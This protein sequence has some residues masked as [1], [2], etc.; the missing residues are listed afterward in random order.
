[1]KIFRLHIATL[2]LMASTAVHAQ[3]SAGKL[4]GGAVISIK[5]NG[6]LF[7]DETNAPSFKLPEF[8]NQSLAGFGTFWI[9]ALNKDGKNLQTAATG[10]NAPEFWSGPIDTF[11]GKSKSPDAWN[12]VWLANWSEIENHRKNFE[13]TNYSVP[14]N[15]AQWPGN[16]AS[17]EGLPAILAPYYDWN[18]DGQ[19]TPKT[20]DFPSIKG[21]E[22]AYL[23]Y[24]D[25]YGEHAA[26]QSIPMKAQV[27]QLVYDLKENAFVIEAYISNRSDEDWKDAYFGFYTDLTL[28]HSEDNYA[29]TIADKNAV[30]GYNG[31][32]LDEGT[33]GYGSSLPYFGIG[34][35]NQKSHSS[36]IFHD[37]GTFRSF[38]NGAELRNIMKGNLASGMQ[39]HDKSNF[40]NPGKSDLANTGLEFSEETAGNLPG[41]RKILNVVG[42]FQI[43][44][45]GYVKL[46]LSVF[47]GV[48]NQPQS[49]ALEH[50]NRVYTEYHASLN[51]GVAEVNHMRI[52]PNPVCLGN[53]ISVKLHGQ[54]LFELN[55]YD[56][57]GKFI[58][59]LKTDNAEI[60][61]DTE[62]LN[63]GVYLLNIRNQY[64][65]ETHKIVIIH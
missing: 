11:T 25:E 13:Q 35:L 12:K 59:Q 40:A 18:R 28:G 41:R 23:M 5:A 64:I 47:G 52:Y 53:K 22:A 8:Q 19:Y 60:E 33:L 55:M 49:A 27:Q 26:S 29:A 45:N 56:S 6:V 63:R 7:S 37:T 36:M 10:T 16:S 58:R 54:G 46:E 39:K 21:N 51:T 9:S 15:I 3:V 44:V 31:D 61:I 38:N 24:N 20:G 30:I 14:Q 42:P 1:M 2:L 57:N 50:W 43:P 4:N 34:W 17:G 48:S 65:S 32:N 62:G